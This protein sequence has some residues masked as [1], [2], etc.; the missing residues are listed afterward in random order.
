MRLATWNVNSLGARLPLVLEW[1]EANGPDI[2]CMQETKLADDA[3]PEKAF[4]GLGYES[5]HHGDGRWNG[6]ALA[7]KVGIESPTIGLGSEE[8]RHGCRMISATCGGVRVH[9]VYVPN[10]RSL[11]SEH[12]RFKLAWLERLRAYLGEH[13][14][15]G[16]EVAVCGDFNVAPDDADVWDA[17]QLVGMT[18]V[19][20]PE[21]AALA[22]VMDWGLV[23][24][25]RR[26]HPEG[27]VFSWWDYRAGNFHKGIGMRID[28]VLLSAALADR[29]VA[30][31]IDRT[32]RKKSPAGNKPSDHTVVVVDLA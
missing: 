10:G 21:R 6:V 5:V 16:A 25:F 18:H 19:S 17:S 28:L 20:E 1:M 24:V 12:Y 26:L 29:C 7:S 27:G 11:D 13:C 15:P 3:F 22:D 14:D 2:L 31:E 4:A 23:D 8:D 9:S 30:A 32:A